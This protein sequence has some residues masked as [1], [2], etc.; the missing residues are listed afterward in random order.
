[1]KYKKINGKFFLVKDGVVTATEVTEEII[2]ASNATEEVTATEPAPADD[3]TSEDSAVEVA[4]MLSKSVKAEAQ[5]IASELGNIKGLNE[6]MKAEMKSIF[7][8]AEVKN[9]GFTSGEGKS[10]K[11]L[12]AKEVVEGFKSVK[13]Q[14]NTSFSVD[15]SDVK[16]LSEINSLTGNV[17]LE[18]RKTDITRAP[19]RP[20]FIQDLITS[21]TT[22]SDKV[23][24]VEA[25]TE[26]GNPAVTAELALIP[27][28][29]YE[30]A[31]FETPVRKIGVTHKASNEILEDAPQLYSKVKSWLNEDMMLKAENEI[32]FGS[33]L[34]GQ[35]TGLM[36]VSPT[37]AA[38][39]FAG[40][41]TAPN[42]F[43]VIRV[44]ANQI[45]TA[46][47]MR[48][49]PS[50]IVMNPEDVTKMDLVKDANN[51][52]IMPPFV[53]ADKTVI[54]GIVVVENP[55]ITAGEFLMG[56]FRKAVKAT[57]RGLN[58]QVSTE[59]E[60]D[61]VK[62]MVTIRLTE[63]FAFYVRNNDIGAFVK[64]KFATAIAAL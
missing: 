29:D 5:K 31:V 44:A 63:R 48:Y 57:R 1:M 11:S 4:K 8:G 34:A 56:D 41:V 40:T 27:E 23:T 18:D 45:K 53:T 39:A 46:S 33:G 35:F 54:K 55:A 38:G 2:A 58:M 36:T 15:F 14:M 9:S 24:Y 21:E 28:K 6:S 64:G 17:I 19:V 47:K 42:E 10:L 13:G 49:M 59:N 30:F 26:A 20:T 25:V 60:N 32:L 61:F 50:A 51:N 62:D 43:D 12:S 3:T 7:A 22:G 37:F 52:Y 16:T